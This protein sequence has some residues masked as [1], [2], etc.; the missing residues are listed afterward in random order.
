MASTLKNVLLEIL[1]LF[2]LILLLSIFHLLMLLV[3]PKD[4]LN[5]PKD[6]AEDRAQF[7]WST[8]LHRTFNSAS[9]YPRFTHIPLHLSPNGVVV[10]AHVP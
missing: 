8:T 2:L 9:N 7:T 4:S 6:K 1:P 3:H 5:M 10:P